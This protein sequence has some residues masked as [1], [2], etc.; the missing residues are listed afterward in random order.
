MNDLPQKCFSGFEAFIVM[1]AKIITQKFGTTPEPKVF[2]ANHNLRQNA[3]ATT[4][5]E[6]INIINGYTKKQV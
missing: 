4:V 2:P 5:F 6:R 1:S 3:M